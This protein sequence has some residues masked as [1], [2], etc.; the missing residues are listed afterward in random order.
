[1][2]GDRKYVGFWW[3]A[4]NAGNTIKFY[5]DANNLLV[6]F[7]TNSLTT[8]LG[9]GGNITAINGSEYAKLAYFGN[10]NPPAGRIPTETYGYVNLLLQGTSTSFGRIVIGH[11]GGG[12]FELDNLAVADAAAVPGTWVNYETVPI[13]LL[14]GA[15]GSNNDTAITPR[16]VPVS[17]NVATNDKTVAGSTFVVTTQPPNGSV[18]IDDPATGAFTYK[19]KTGF[20]G[21]DTFTYQQC[22]PAP[23]QAE[24]AT[25]SVK[26]TVA[27]DAVNDTE[28]TEVNT[29]LT[30]SVAKND[31]TLAG[32]TFTTI[33]LPTNGSLV[34]PLNLA[35]GEYTYKPNTGYTGTDTFVY[36]LCL[37]APNAGMC[38]D[39]TVTITIAPQAV[40][41]A[42]SVSITGTP[43]VGQTLTGNY[44]YTDVN[45]DLEGISTFRW[46]R[47]PTNSVVGG[48]NVGNASGYTTVPADDGS[49]MFF[50]VTP[51]AVTGLSPGVEV[52]SPGARLGAV[53]PASIPTLS[54]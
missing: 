41:V 49:Y 5:D 1:M 6:T 38:D 50:C 16:D 48:V 28:A 33:T 21:E 29:P 13:N 40:P 30:A 39:A 43:S 25:A 31:F 27:P 42:S 35:T 37:P 23:D 45:A 18:T 44:T 53:A 15:I 54:Q 10:P 19:P 22:K 46:V 34:S 4:G 2:T 32:S 9:G 17:G 20:V 36:R 47:S 12:S 14:A 11:Q 51:V 3:S 24:C 26:V 7:T 8:L 52:C